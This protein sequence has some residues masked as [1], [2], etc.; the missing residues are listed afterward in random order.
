ML[1]I[2]FVNYFA[3]TGDLHFKNCT[4]LENGYVVDALET[5]ISE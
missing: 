1:F 3:I 5:C 4:L 2:G